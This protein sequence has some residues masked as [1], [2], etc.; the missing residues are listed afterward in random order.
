M[1]VLEGAAV[2]LWVRVNTDVGVYK[3]LKVVLAVDE[4][5]PDEEALCV[6]N[7][8]YVF[9]GVFV[10]ACDAPVDPLDVAELDDERVTFADTL[11]DMLPVLEIIGVRVCISVGPSVL[12]TDVVFEGG[13]VRLPHADEVLVFDDVIDNVPVSDIRDVEVNLGLDEDERV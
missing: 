11:D 6:S 2:K 9:N 13:L 3:P 7:A 1:L 12:L 4:Y 8:L 10:Y 5:E